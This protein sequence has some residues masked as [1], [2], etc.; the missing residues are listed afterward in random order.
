MNKELV[1]STLDEQCPDATI[2]SGCAPGVDTNAIEWAVS[3]DQPVIRFPAQWSEYG[4]SAGFIRNHQM[5]REGRPTLVIAFQYFNYET[6]GTQNMIMIT[7]LARVPLL[8]VKDYP[9]CLS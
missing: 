2:I 1:F 9:P 5:I 4:H 3:R 6:P 8:I 7:R